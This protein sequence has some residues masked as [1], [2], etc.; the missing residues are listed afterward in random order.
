MVIRRPRMSD[1]TVT[2]VSAEDY[3]A[4]YAD[5]Y[6]EWVGGEIIRISPVSQRHDALTAYFRHWV[7]AYLELN[8]I[9]RAFSAPFVMRLAHSFREP[10]I[11]IVLADNPH[12]LTD[13]AL[14]GGAD[15]CLGGLA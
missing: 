14:H 1:K 12:T 13:M 3:L 6:C 9:G 8:P 11:Q 2:G 5:Q 10:D 7:D 15:I 4:T